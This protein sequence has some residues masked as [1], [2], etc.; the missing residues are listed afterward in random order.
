MR[1]PM[2]VL[3]IIA[4]PAVLPAQP[5]GRFPPDSLV[6]TKVIPHNTPVIQVIGMMRNFA[7]D[8]G[9][10]CQFC[11][12]GEEGLPLERFD[13]AK[14]EKRTKLVA[15][16]MM[17]MVQE[18]NRRIDTLP[19]KTAPGLQVTCGTCHRGTSRPVPLF[20]LLVDAAQA[21]GADSSIRAYR[22][23]RERYYGRDA[24]DFGESSLNI[25]AFRLGRAQRFDDAFALLALN[26]EQFPRSSVMYV[27]R[28]NLFLMRGDTTS[29]ATAFRE[30]VRRDSTNVEARQRLQA[31][32]QRP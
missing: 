32:G 26:E 3:A 16:Q 27:F 2:L 4:V 28:G 11:H 6:N 24:Y 9:V 23:L 10:R 14:D 17:Q 18:I 25:A 15:R 13:F 5:P 29:A 1:S 12:V 19:G 21:A 8:L 31:I 20:T 7:G 30:A 22:A